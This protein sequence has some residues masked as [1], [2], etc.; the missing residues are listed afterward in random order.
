MS[1]AG[2]TAMPSTPNFTFTGLAT[3]APSLG[4]TK[5]TLSAALAARLALNKTAPAKPAQMRAN[6]TACIMA[7]SLR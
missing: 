3:V 2:L 5:Y 1:P 6:D 4:S 7:S